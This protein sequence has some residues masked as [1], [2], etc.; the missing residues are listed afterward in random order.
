MA[1]YSFKKGWDMVPQ[2]K[3]PEI[4]ER[5][6]S[7]LGIGSDPQ[8]YNR[9]KG[10]PEPLISEYEAITAIFADYGITDIWGD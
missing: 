10:N 8:F 3:A 6:K 5:I 2:A 9:L 4:R 1:R 7:A